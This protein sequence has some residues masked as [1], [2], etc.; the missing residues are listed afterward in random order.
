MA[1]WAPSAG[2]PASGSAIVIARSERIGWGLDAEKVAP[3]R[4]IHNDAARPSA[5]SQTRSESRRSARVVAR[6][7]GDTGPDE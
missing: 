2:T 3:K 1:T 6:Q 5:F 7:V 4:P